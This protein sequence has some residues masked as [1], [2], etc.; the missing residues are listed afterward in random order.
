[1]KRQV[2]G[3][4][5]G[6]MLLGFGAIAAYYKSLTPMQKEALQDRALDDLA[7]GKT[8]VDSLRMQATTKFNQ[9]VEKLTD[10]ETDVAWRDWVAQLQ[11]KV[12]DLTDQA[13]E[14]YQQV[15]EMVQA[16]ADDHLSAQ[17]K[18]TL[19]EMQNRYQELK[20]QAQKMFTEARKSLKQQEEPLQNLANETLNQTEDDFEIVLDAQQDD[21]K[22]AL[23]M[24][25]VEVL[26]P[27]SSKSDNK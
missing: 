17:S 2:K 25:D 14:Q 12:I 15:R 24:N 27:E 6:G 3:L 9:Q 26:Q 1:M 21:V 8:K 23:G 4:I 7:K 16:E 11:M 13:N 22:E 20:V 5:F 10:A 19:A 18:E